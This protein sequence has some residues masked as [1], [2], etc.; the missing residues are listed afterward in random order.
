MFCPN[1]R[2]QIGDGAKF[3]AFCGTAFQSAAYQQYPAT[4]YAGN[5]AVRQ[6]IP[7][8]GFSDRVQ[9]PEILAAVKKNR[10]AAGIAAFF[11][12]P[13]PLIGFVIYS[14]VSDGM[15]TADAVK[16]G[17]IVS[18]VFLVFA[19]F[20]FIR[21]RA[22]NS[23]EAVVTDKKASQVYRRSNSDSAGQVMQYVTVVQTTD[24]KRKKITEHE[25]SRIIAYHY[26]NI[27]DRFRYH[28]QFAFPYERYDKSNAPY[29]C[30][31]GCGRQNPVEADRCKK[32]NL[33]LL[34]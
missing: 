14:V 12:V 5:G 18:A 16:Y 31:V 15:E 9:H 19:L 6:G 26:L 4:V 29:L 3:C 13:L 20:G 17:A 28:P 24:G 27:G 7:A 25:G 34:K 22:G 10:K 2:N 1:C 33:P 8:P 30:C 32:C 23:Y 11:I 21:E